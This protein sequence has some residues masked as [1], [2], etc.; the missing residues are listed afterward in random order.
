MAE[1]SEKE[2]AA[3]KERKRNRPGIQTEHYIMRIEPKQK[4]NLLEMAEAKGMFMSEFVN[5]LLNMS[6][7]SYKKNGGFPAVSEPAKEEE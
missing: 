1:I 7:H 3:R 6:W 2:M 4:S 5:W